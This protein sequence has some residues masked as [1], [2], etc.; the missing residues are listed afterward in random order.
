MSKRKKNFYVV[1]KGREV[2]IFDNWEDCK[3]AVDGFSGSEYKGFSNMHDAEVYFQ[4]KKSDIKQPAVYNVSRQKEAEEK[5]CFF[6]VR[7]GWK[8]GIY[9]TWD[10]CWQAINGY[11]GSEAKDFATETEALQYMYEGNDN[12]VGDDPVDNEERELL[13]SYYMDMYMDDKAPH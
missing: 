8:T 12:G 11:S 9:K 5:S 10:G 13:E 2:G 1:K 7:K 4:G 6:A 3:K